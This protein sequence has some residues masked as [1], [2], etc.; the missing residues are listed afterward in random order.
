MT[1]ASPT[2]QPGRTTDPRRTH[3]VTPLVQVAKALPAIGGVFLALQSEA[4]TQFATA[5]ALVVTLAF[6]V[7]VAFWSYL[8][9]L[10][11]SFWFDA[12][13][14]LRVR[15]GLFEVNE[16]R[17]Q[18][19]RLQSVDVTQPLLARLFGLAAVRPEV[20]G[21]GDK[22]TRVEYLTIDDAQ[23][24]RA[25][26]LA[27]AAGVVGEDVEAAAP[28]A[29]ESVVLSVPAPALLESVVL[30][31]RT[32]WTAVVAVGTIL[33]AALTRSWELS[34]PGL[35]VIVSP[36]VFVTTQ[37]LN[38]FGFTVA[39]SPDGLRLRFGL[40]EHKVQTVPPGRVQAVRFERPLLWRHRGWVRVWVN[41]AGASSHDEGKQRP[42]LLIP[43][44]PM[45]VARSVVAQ[46]LP[47]VDPFQ[48][49]LQPVPARARWRAPLQGP[50]LA[51]GANER[52][53]VA[54]HGWLVPTWDVVPHARTQ[55]VRVTQGPWQRRL[56]LA[57]LHLD[58][59]PGRIRVTAA[60]RPA[61]EVRAW[62]QAQTDRAA[63]A[64]ATAPPE[65]WMTSGPST[66]HPDS[67]SPT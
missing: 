55:S 22:G 60:Q 33:I 34:L 32:G 61:D 5:G 43:V 54:R 51:A 1:S 20:A 46:V 15:S 29:P 12:D 56:R 6:C 64:R 47:N 26:L 67:E 30:Q 13:G 24:L 14:D 17:V 65:R 59:T 28:E 11:L 39:H 7:V 2:P 21:S 10:R 18:V 16:R 37:F 44:A 58:S 50:Q 31:S 66:S 3:P 8:H 40:T 4:V 35:L 45:E 27:R 53:F 63:A 42:S 23:R 52:I 36:V 41:V 38:W 19:S 49:A 9:W 25:E 57:S 48:L 62:A